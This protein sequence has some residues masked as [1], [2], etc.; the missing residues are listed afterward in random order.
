M[1][2]TYGFNTYGFNTY[3]FNTYGLDDL[4]RRSQH[5]LGALLPQRMRRKPATPIYLFCHHKVATVL[6]TK[7]FR[8]VG[9][10]NGWTFHVLRGRQTQA[11]R[12]PGVTLFSHAGDAETFAKPFVGV[13]V[14]RDPR[15]VIV[16]GYLYHRRTAEAWC[17]NQDFSTAPS[18]A[19]PQ[20]P[21]SQE[22]RSEAW[23]R[24]YLR[25]LNG[26]SYQEH[27]L[28]LS[29]EE[30]LIFEMKHYGAWTIE[31]MLEW[32]YAQAGVLELKFEALMGSYDATFCSVF[33]H[34]GLSGKQH[35]A[36]MCAA[37]KH[38]LSK[39]SAAEVAAI[40]HV[41]AREPSKWRHYFTEEHHAAFRELFGD[42]LVKLG[43]ETN[44]AAPKPVGR[45][46]PV[47]ATPPTQHAA[48]GPL[49]LHN[50][51]SP[52]SDHELKSPS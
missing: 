41:S 42:A 10:A 31:S 11:P 35:A 21:Y 2:N 12:N 52:A 50:Q 19:F 39:K 28:S 7:V 43:Y 34:L 45:I 15:D 46:R 26:K 4:K 20:V 38:D 27:L 6:L 5:V 29:P 49:K 8:E 13:H 25:S 32:N 51:R 44:P 3:G 48:P 36:G 40:Q 16:S 47:S 37:A 18:I 14:V 17:V 22:H 24:D 9:L 30:G 23:K 1:F 33:E